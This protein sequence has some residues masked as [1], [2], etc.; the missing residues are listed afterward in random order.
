MVVVITILLLGVLDLGRAYFTLL[1]MQDAAGEGA[2]YGAVHPTWVT[3]ANNADPNNIT[4]RV[5]RAAPSGTLVDWNSA[6]V[7][8]DT[9]GGTTIG[10]LITVTVTANYGLLTPFVGALVGSQTLQLRTRSVAVVTSKGP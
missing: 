1:A 8:V 6:T 9:S 3:S 7:S 2:S 5:R 4:Y 10:S